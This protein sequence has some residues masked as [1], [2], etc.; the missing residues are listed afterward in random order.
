MHHGLHVELPNGSSHLD[1]VGDVANQQRA[2]LHEAAMARRQIVVTD[3]E[4][5]GLGDRLGHVS[6][7][8]AFAGHGHGAGGVVGGDVGDAGDLADF[9][10]HAELAVAAGHAFNGEFAG[11]HSEC[12]FFLECHVHPRL[13]P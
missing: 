9:L 1:A 10:F 2:P 3:R 12:P 6:V 8:K 4:K 11:I 7:G 13:Y 5:S